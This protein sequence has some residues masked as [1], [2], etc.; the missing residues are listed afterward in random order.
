MGGGATGFATL[1]QEVA[2]VHAASL[3]LVGTFAQVPELANFLA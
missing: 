2:D 3:A 1:E